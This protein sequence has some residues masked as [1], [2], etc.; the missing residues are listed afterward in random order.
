[1]NEIMRVLT[2]QGVVCIKDGDSWE[3]TVKPRPSDID[4]WSHFLHAPDNNAVVKDKKVG[5]PRALQ[6]VHGQK[7]ARSHEP[8][9]CRSN[10]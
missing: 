7:W 2:P 4:D 5:M 8:S 9:G 1:M 6:W 3:K 10:T